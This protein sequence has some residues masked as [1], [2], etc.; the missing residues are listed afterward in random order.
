ML[1]KLS[2]TLRNCGIDAE[3]ISIRDHEL[4]EAQARK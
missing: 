1:K 4:A 2:S 3:Y